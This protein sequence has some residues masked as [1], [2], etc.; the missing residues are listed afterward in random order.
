MNP[1]FASAIDPIFLHVLG[2]LDR[3]E[4]NKPISPE[5]ERE[6]I[7]NRFREAESQ[8]GERQ[9][10]ELAKYG[11][12]AWIDEVLINA[13]WS[14]NHWWEDNLLEFSYFKTRDRGTEFF[15]KAK[16]AAEMTR[17]DALEVFYICVVLGFRGLYAL[18]EAAF[19]ADQLG[20]PSDIEAWASQTVR[21]IQLNQGRPPIGESM[22]PKSSAPPLSGKFLLVGSLLVATILAAFSV[23]VFWGLFFG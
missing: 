3:I 9:G 10:W 6:S 14:G 15:I 8:M 1:R 21:A 19:L 22:R 18:R 2:L 5:E 12:V 11:L 13:P 4:S 17:R 16:G 23:V 20:L 7:R